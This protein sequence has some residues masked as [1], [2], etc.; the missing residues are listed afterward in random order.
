M[1]MEESQKASSWFLEVWLV[2]I[3]VG[4]ICNESL[5]D[6]ETQTGFQMPGTV[7]HKAG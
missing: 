5:Y 1:Q 2:M 7:T 3:H 6:T 4:N